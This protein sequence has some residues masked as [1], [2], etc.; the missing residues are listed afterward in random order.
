MVTFFPFDAIIPPIHVQ[1]QIA[2]FYT[3]QQMWPL[4]SSHFRQRVIVSV[5]WN[6]NNFRKFFDLQPFVQTYRRLINFMYCVAQRQMHPISLKTKYVNKIRV[7][8][9]SDPFVAAIS[10]R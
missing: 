9:Y 3:A 8:N 10:D 7:D 6:N 1:D 5:P 2:L 4:L